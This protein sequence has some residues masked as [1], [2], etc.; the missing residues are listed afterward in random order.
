MQKVT[1]RQEVIGS[2]LQPLSPDVSDKE[3][4]GHDALLDGVLG[5][6]KVISAMSAET[7]RYPATDTGGRVQEATLGCIPEVCGNP[8]TL[9]NSDSVHRARGYTKC[10]RN[11]NWT[12]KE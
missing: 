1:P 3:C 2:G 11:G 7:Y 5:H 10:G 8:Q 12:E 6:V 9:P 4:F